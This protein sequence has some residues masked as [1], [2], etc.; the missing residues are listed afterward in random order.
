ML[1]NGCAKNT[2]S[3]A[4][5]STTRRRSCAPTCFSSTTERAYAGWIASTCRSDSE[6]ASKSSRRS[7]ADSR[8]SMSDAPEARLVAYNV[9]QGGPRDPDVWRGILSRLS[10]DLLFVQESRNAE[11]SW[12]RAMPG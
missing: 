6:I 7:Q 4:S 11:D 2:L 3:C 12:L 1:S 8:A 5:T 10:P 9:G